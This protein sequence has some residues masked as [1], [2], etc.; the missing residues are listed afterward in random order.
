[1]EHALIWL[2]M[3]ASIP[4][5]KTSPFAQQDKIKDRLQDQ[6][7]LK[8]S[9][10]CHMQRITSLGMSQKTI[11]WGLGDLLLANKRLRK[12]NN[13]T[14]VCLTC[15]GRDCSSLSM[16]SSCNSYTINAHHAYQLLLLLPPPPSEA[17][18]HPAMHMEVQ[19]MITIFRS[20]H[21][22]SNDP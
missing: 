2:L 16:I 21:A 3:V 20:H 22:G 18:W 17:R 19:A 5:Q 7:K 6:I 4:S 8:C 1:M 13:T 9:R 10:L 11:V 14:V 12:T 15:D